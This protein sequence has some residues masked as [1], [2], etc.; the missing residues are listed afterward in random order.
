LTTLA[1]LAASAAK[2]ALIV[3]AVYAAFLGVVY[4]FQDRLI[5]FPHVGRD[6]AVTPAQFG[7]T[8]EEVAIATADGETLNAWW[9]P[10]PHARGAALILHGNAGNISQRLD[11]AR[12]FRDFGYATLLV[13]Y[14]GYGRSTGRPSEEGTYCDADAAWRWLTETR[15]LAANEIVIYGESL[16]GAVSCRLAARVSP[17]ALVLASTF[18]SLPDLGAEIY[19]FLPVRLLSRYRYDTRSCIR[20]VRVPVMVIHSRSDEIVP[21]HHG[22]ALYAAANEP[23]SFLEIGGGHNDS[24]VVERPEWREAL[25]RFLSVP[26]L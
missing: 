1:S 14:R 25:G 9:L 3:A 10:T 22:E 7:R 17:R 6:I 4:L 5:Y 21:F 18:T 8:F 2:I 13:D 20:G 15:G 19:P 24:S 12:M 16:G 23:K 26:G 11:Y